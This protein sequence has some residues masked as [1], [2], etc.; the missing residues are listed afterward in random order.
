MMACQQGHFEVARAIQDLFLSDSGHSRAVDNEDWC[1]LMYAAYRGS[2]DMREMQILFEHFDENAMN[3]DRAVC[4]DTASMRRSFAFI[5]AA[6]VGNL[7]TVKI[8]L[9]A[10]FWSVDIDAVD[11]NFMSALA[12]AAQQGHTDVVHALLEHNADVHVVN[13]NSMSVFMYA[14][15]SGKRDILC[16]LL[17]KGVNINHVASAA[18]GRSTAVMCA[19]AKRNFDLVGWL[20]EKGADANCRYPEPSRAVGNLRGRAVGNLTLLLLAVCDVELGAEVKYDLVSKL[21]AAGADVNAVDDRCVT[22]LMNVA[23]E[24]DVRLATLL[25]KAGAYLYL[26]DLKGRTVMHYAYMPPLGRAS[27]NAYAA[28][29]QKWHQLC[30]EDANMA[31]LINEYDMNGASLINEYGMNPMAQLLTDWAAFK[32]NI[33]TPSRSPHGHPMGVADNV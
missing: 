11:G 13:Q 14:V 22:A 31:N 19:Y 10:N 4:Y 18:F 24:G 26:A 33:S 17:D 21:L 12:H 20:L 1:A 28:L 29:L 3:L 7:E 32:Q 27:T 23:A 25:L 6:K 30:R 16:A 5:I 9:T 15:N 8:F 2:F